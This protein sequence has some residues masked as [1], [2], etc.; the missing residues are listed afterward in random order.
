MAQPGSTHRPIACASL[1]RL[2][3]SHVCSFS[4]QVKLRE[5]IMSFAKVPEETIHMLVGKESLN[6]ND[7]KRSRESGDLRDGNG[8]A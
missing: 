5:V 3:S 7:E 2:S 6:N 4:R 8:H 1:A